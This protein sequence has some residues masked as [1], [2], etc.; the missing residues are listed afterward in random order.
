[1]LILLRYISWDKFS[2]FFRSGRFAA[3]FLTQDWSPDCHFTRAL[4]QELPGVRGLLFPTSH[5]QQI[6]IDVDPQGREL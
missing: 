1:M 3:R 6:L 2:S 5:T 4:S